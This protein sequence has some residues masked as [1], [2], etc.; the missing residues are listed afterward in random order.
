MKVIPIHKVHSLKIKNAIVLNFV[1]SAVCF[2]K[3]YKIHNSFVAAVVCYNEDY[4]KSFYYN[5][6]YYGSDN[7]FI[8]KTWKKKVKQL[9]R[10]EELKI[11]I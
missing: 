6:G 9:K 3:N 7:D 5:G 11:F 10:E 1:L 2:Y 4:Y 8:N